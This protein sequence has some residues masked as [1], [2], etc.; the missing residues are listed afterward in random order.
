LQ[1]I[2]AQMPTDDKVRRATYVIRTDG[3]FEDTNRQVRNIY[4][5]LMIP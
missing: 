4:D 5:Q 2:A 1:R 3:T